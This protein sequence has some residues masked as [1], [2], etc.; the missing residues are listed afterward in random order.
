ML[1][2]RRSPKFWPDQAVA[3]TPGEIADV[4]RTGEISPD[5]WD[6]PP[7]FTASEDVEFEE[8]SEFIRTHYVVG[9]TTVTLMSQGIFNYF[10]KSCVR[11]IV[12]DEKG[13][14]ATCF[15]PLFSCHLG[16]K[17][18]MLGQTTYLCIRK[19]LSG[20]GMAG[21]IIRRVM[22]LASHQNVYI[23]YHQVEK[24]IGTNA[25]S[26]KGWWYPLKHKGL[27]PLGFVL[28]VKGSH[29]KIRQHFQL[30]EKKGLTSESVEKH[31]DFVRSEWEK[32]PVRMSWNTFQEFLTTSSELSSKIIC[33]NGT[34]KSLFVVRT[35]QICFLTVQEERPISLIQFFTSP[36]PEIFSHCIGKLETS[37]VYFHELGDVNQKFLESIHA[38]RSSERWCNWYN[39]TGQY[40]SA[41]IFLPML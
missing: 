38:V 28:P 11:V 16:E 19:D 22:V 41:D 5:K 29:E 14:A 35:W 33:Q 30:P 7:G 13:I 15:A 6:L 8:L 32:F 2:S 17:E 37:I 9:G 18:K 26:L 10:Q 21:P 12:R 23:G 31:W 36:T 20:K 24:P 34:P 3:R 39:W 40:Q 4:I 1:H 25:V 27:S